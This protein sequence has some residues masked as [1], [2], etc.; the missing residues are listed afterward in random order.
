MVKHITDSMGLLDEN[1][2]IVSISADPVFT[3][4]HPPILI[5]VHHNLSVP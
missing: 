5:T 3:L 1:R 2:D 4:S